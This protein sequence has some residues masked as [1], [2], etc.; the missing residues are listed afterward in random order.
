MT[1]S[2]KEIQEVYQELDKIRQIKKCKSCECLLDVL[3]A[4][5]DDL[6]TILVNGTENVKDGFKRWLEEG[7]KERHKCLG[8]EECLPIAPYN[9]F[10]AVLNSDEPGFPIMHSEGSTAVASCDCGGT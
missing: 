3:E 2:E 5:Q 1:I 8:C 9:K 6:S 10:N 7:Q 4:M